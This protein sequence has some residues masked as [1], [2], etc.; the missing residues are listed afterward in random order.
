MRIEKR[1]KID[2]TKNIAEEI[3]RKAVNFMEAKGP[4]LYQQLNQYCRSD[5]YPFHMPGHKRKADVDLMRD[6]P[7]PY[8]IDITEIDGFDNLHHAEG[9]IQE[10][11]EWAASV[12]G[13]DRTYYLVNG[14][15]CGVLSAICASAD[16]GDTILMARNSHRSAYNAVSIQGLNVRYL[17]PQ[18]IEEFGLQGGILPKDVARALEI[19]DALSQT[20]ALSQ[21]NAL[22]QT[23][24]SA[25]AAGHA[26]NDRIA[27]VFI[28]S[29]TYDGVVS[30]IRA[31]A[32]ICHSH[33]VPLI[34]D[35]A[36]GAHFHFGQDFPVSALELGADVVIHSL[37]KTLPAF[38]QTALLH[39]RGKRIDIKKL[40]YY[41][42]LFE[43]SSPSY[44]LMAGIEQCIEYMSDKG[45]EKMRKF[46]CR[47]AQLRKSLGRMECLRLLDRSVVG[48]AGVYDL[49][50]SKV[51]VSGGRSHFSAPYISGVEL[52]DRL[53]RDYHLEMEMAGPD[54]VT[55]IAT[56]MD[57]ED[58]FRR[59]EKAFLEIDHQLT[60][61]ECYHTVPAAG[62]YA[63][64]KAVPFPAPVPETGR[65]PSSPASGNNGLSSPAPGNSGLPSPIPIHQALSGPM[66]TVPVEQS[67]G[68]ISGEYIYLYPPG[69]PIIVPGEVLTR[70]IIETICSYRTQQLPIQGLR[71][72]TNHRIQVLIS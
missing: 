6:F 33:G 30:D 15:T 20:D 60:Q 23:D 50:C 51:I 45:L 43:T 17:F 36:H 4:R 27:A 26:R 68:R 28:T 40:E 69:I 8:S 53:R 66:Q 29:P 54:Y 31:I 52:T 58:G 65:P 13:A 42:Q 32:D 59:L 39:V 10:S 62:A 67:T 19:G 38:T 61:A 24:A 25:Q 21:A 71:D 18:I 37:H 48:R 35:E 3:Q 9:I 12:Y 44:I 49:D 70:E 63:G 55:A 57:T 14:S 16:R 7:N 47:L 22:S 34:V 56:L 1:P 72:H 64:H 46:S 5:A 41:L 2:Y 11:M